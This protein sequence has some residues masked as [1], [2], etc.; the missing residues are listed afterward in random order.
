MLTL[1]CAFTSVSCRGILTWATVYESVAPDGGAKLQ[2]QVAGCFAD[3]AVRVVVK[4]GWLTERIAAG[5]DCA[6]MFAHAEW[7]GDTV[8]AF[9]D[10]FYCGRIQVAYDVRARR[11]VDFGV[12]EPW[13]RS[14][15]VRTY[16][17]TGDE[18]KEH[19]GDVFQ[20]VTYP[21]GGRSAEEFRR[22]FPRP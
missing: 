5:N 2:V 22:R 18:L 17:V 6:V 16:G 21:G 12:A 4:R 9:V 13:L 19:Q 20:W 7:A 8:A 3:C 11:A 1:F 15:I 10:G 14:S